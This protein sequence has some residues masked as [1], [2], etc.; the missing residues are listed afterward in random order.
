MLLPARW[1]VPVGI[2]QSH[3]S[4]LAVTVPETDAAE[5]ASNAVT[6]AGTANRFHIQC[7]LTALM[8]TRTL[9]LKSNCFRYEEFNGSNFQLQLNNFKCLLL[10]VN[11]LKFR[12]DKGNRTKK[13]YYENRRL[14]AIQIM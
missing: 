12:G 9:H 11:Q 6:F 13:G 14:V 1:A 3:P 7:L 10:S 2:L 5:L 8:A 4:V